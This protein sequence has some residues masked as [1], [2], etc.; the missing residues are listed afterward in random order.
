MT[1]EHDQEVDTRLLEYREAIFRMTKARILVELSKLTQHE[2]AIP[3][4]EPS[5]DEIRS[6]IERLTSEE[7]FGS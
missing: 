2:R 1:D 6:M 3:R 4:Y 7:V 5:Y